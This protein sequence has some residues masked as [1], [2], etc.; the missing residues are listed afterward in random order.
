MAKYLI[1]LKDID[2]LVAF[3]PKKDLWYLFHRD[4]PTQQ[5]K[6][7]STAMQRDELKKQFVQIGVKMFIE[8][9]TVD[10]IKEVLDKK[11][12]AN[13]KKPKEDQI[14][15]NN[16]RILL[17]KRLSSYIVSEGIQAFFDQNLDDDQLSSVAE[18]LES[19]T[20][21]KNRQKLLT[22]IEAAMMSHG[23]RIYLESLSV[24][25]L[26][27]LAK[28]LNIGGN[29]GSRSKIVLI[30]G[31]MS[32]DP[33]EKPATKKEAKISKKKPKLA[34]GITPADLTYHF[35]VDELRDYAKANS[36]SASGRK[37]V[38]IKRILKLHLSTTSR[39]RKG[40]P[41]SKVSASKRHKG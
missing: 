29:Y 6:H 30:T 26:Q 25:F 22:A 8:Q 38:L 23:M 15:F 12:K 36:I 9:L 3:F 21:P 39:K 33:I 20:V 13:E 40:S 32:G 11:I 2:E 35:K 16:T 19:P 14:P 10:Q 34:P 37:A 27:Q 18:L 28:S 17:V 31:I 41:N 4:F 7:T 1:D 5:K 24:D